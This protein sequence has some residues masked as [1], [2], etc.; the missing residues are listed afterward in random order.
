MV[1]VYVLGYDHDSILHGI[2]CKNS[3]IQLYTVIGAPAVIYL[4][5]FTAMLEG[6]SAILSV[7]PNI[8]WQLL[9][10][11]VQE[12]LWLHTYYYTVMYYSNV[13]CIAAYSNRNTAQYYTF[14]ALGELANFSSQI[15]AAHL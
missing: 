8:A 12:D 13:G 14:R 9:H 1:H 11:M 3:V 2:Y 15:R 4:W 6:S 5:Q 7:T 10:C